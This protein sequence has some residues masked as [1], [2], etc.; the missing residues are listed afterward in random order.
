VYLHIINKINLKRERDAK[1]LVWWRIH[2][3][4]AFRRQRQ[5]DLYE[6]KASLVSVGSSRTTRAPS[7]TISKF[8]KCHGAWLRAE[9]GQRKGARMQLSWV[10]LASGFGWLV[11]WLV[12][13]F[14]FLL[15][16]LLLR[17]PHVALKHTK[18]IPRVTL[19]ILSP[20]AYAWA[21]HPAH[22]A[23]FPSLRLAYGQQ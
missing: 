3:F 18:C 8:K 20:A 12:F 16:L 6:F 2:L 14:G 1:S 17:Q 21:A 4:P 22:D 23:C 5:V 9:E 19:N 13:D 10:C 7:E 11:G 15:L